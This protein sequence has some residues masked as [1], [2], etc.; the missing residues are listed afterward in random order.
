LKPGQVPEHLVEI[1]E[2]A[3]ARYALGAD[4]TSILAALTK[5]ESGFGQNMGPSSAGAIGWTQFLPSTWE[6]YGVDADGDGRRD[7]YDPDD[8]IYAAANYLH[9]SGAPRDWHR[10]LFAY[11]H[12]DQYV[13]QVLALADRFA[14]DSSPINCSV[15]ELV[16]GDALRVDGGGGL[17]VIPGTGGQQV[18]ER[19]LSDVT[20]L[21]AA[22]HVTV[23]A[24][25]APSGHKAHGEHPLGL[26][27]DLVP[28]PGG[29]WD[30]VDR[31][32]AWAEPQQNHPRAPFRWVGYDGDPDHGRGNHLHLSW[33]HAPAQPGVAPPAWVMTLGMSATTAPRPRRG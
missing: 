32:A 6:R 22:Y 8:A 16:A 24:G 11:N 14:H 19:I 17:A 27:V 4:G 15:E 2:G 13:D 23:T 12:S 25:F 21:I 10:A 29:S 33:M 26:A 31:L 7:P 28:G 18:D 3:A 1:F 9:A 30:D 20:Y 5:I